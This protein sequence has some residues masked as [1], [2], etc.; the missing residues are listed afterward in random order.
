MKPA[1][2]GSEWVGAAG[3][4][5]LDWVVA[6]G[7]ERR[8]TQ[9]AVQSWMGQPGEDGGLGAQFNTLGE[10]GSLRFLAFVPE[11]T[12]DLLKHESQEEALLRK[13]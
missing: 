7:V 4:Q 5:D 3:V 10:K 1:L 12:M 2:Q 13:D 6:T 8:E 11:E 9:E